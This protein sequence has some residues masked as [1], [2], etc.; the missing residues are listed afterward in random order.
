[1]TNNFFDTFN[2]SQ[3]FL[4]GFSITLMVTNAIQIVLGVFII[5]E[6]IVSIIELLRFFERI[7]FSGHFFVFITLAMVIRQVSKISETS[8]NANMISD[9]VCIMVNF[10]S[11]KYFQK[12]NLEKK[13]LFFTQRDFS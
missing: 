9:V 10:F 6:K 1:M 2:L 7:V 3:K 11:H 8:F 12:K 13:I 4:L 5:N